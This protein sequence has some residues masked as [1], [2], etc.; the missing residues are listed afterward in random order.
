MA[1]F[2]WIGGNPGEGD[3]VLIEGAEKDEGIGLAIEGTKGQQ[4]LQRANLAGDAPWP[5][6]LPGI[7]RPSD[8]D[9]AR[10]M[11]V[12]EP[13]QL[14]AALFGELI[15]HAIVGHPED[16]RANVAAAE[17]DTPTETFCEN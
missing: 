1:V 14:A 15:S 2:A 6:Q 7:G 4:S 16:G 9:L 8:A 10:Q 3:S 11:G 17:R 13:D 5:D 12:N